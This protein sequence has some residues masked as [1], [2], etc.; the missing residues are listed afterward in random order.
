MEKLQTGDLV[1][2]EHIGKEGIGYIYDNG[3]DDE[4]WL[5]LGISWKDGGSSNTSLK[6]AIEAGAIFTKVV[7]HSIECFR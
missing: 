3:S 4:P 7:L 6:A 5:A 2:I 1:K